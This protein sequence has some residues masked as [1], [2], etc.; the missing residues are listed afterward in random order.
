LREGT[1]FF[2][3]KPVKNE[4]SDARCTRLFSLILNTELDMATAKSSKSDKS[5]KK[6]KG[7]KA[8][9]S[10][11]SERKVVKEGKEKK[12]AKA[13]KEDKG[14]LG[15]SDLITRKYDEHVVKRLI[16]E[17]PLREG[18]SRAKMWEKLKAGMT[19]AQFLAACKGAYEG[20][21]R[22]ELRHYVQNGWVK[23]RRPGA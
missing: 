6:S 15:K 18:T 3:G 8:A 19:V 9:T 23:L 14:S 4:G 22:T 21:G 11:K 20:R 5:S 2:G 10:E 1:R 16:K 7:K 13:K 12:K 17:N